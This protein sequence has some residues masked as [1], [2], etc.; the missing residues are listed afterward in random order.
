MSDTT[1]ATAT[2]AATCHEFIKSG[3][4]LREWQVIYY[5]AAAVLSES[6]RALSKLNEER[7]NEFM[8]EAKEVADKMERGLAQLTGLKSRQSSQQ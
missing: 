4:T 5:N 2:A 3:G 8:R 7:H 1:K 6:E